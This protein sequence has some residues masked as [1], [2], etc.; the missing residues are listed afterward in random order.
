MIPIGI[1]FDSD[2]ERPTPAKPASAADADRDP[3]CFAGHDDLD[4]I[5]FDPGLGGRRRLSR[6]RRRM[7]IYIRP[8][9]G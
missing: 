7:R 6:H 9:R 2:A 8:R 4:R 5:G 1:G 3:A